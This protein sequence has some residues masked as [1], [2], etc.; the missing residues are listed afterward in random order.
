MATAAFCHRMVQDPWLSADDLQCFKEELSQSTF[1]ESPGLRNILFNLRPSEPSP[2]Q[3]PP[4]PIFEEK[5]PSILHYADLVQALDSGVLDGESPY[6][7][8]GLSTSECARLAMELDPSKDYE[9]SF[10]PTEPKIAFTES[11]A[12]VRDTRHESKQ[13]GGKVRATIRPA[14][15]ASHHFD[16][17][18]P[19][20]LDL[21]AGVQG[22][23]R[24]D[25]IA[26]EY[27]SAYLRSL[28]ACGDA[29][30]L[31]QELDLPTGTRTFGA[32]QADLLQVSQKAD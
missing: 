10:V 1:H 26:I 17:E 24:Y 8:D 28:A 31:Y 4:T 20:H 13:K 27:G 30:R 19:W 6:R 3:M 25:F 29:D 11:G 22:S 14:L 16:I 21:L 7:V 5:A 15:A 23:K 18:T 32:R 12:S 9:S 2:T